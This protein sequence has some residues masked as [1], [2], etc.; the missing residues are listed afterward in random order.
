MSGQ[1]WPV[2]QLRVMWAGVE[3]ADPVGRTVTQRGPAVRRVMETGHA[4]AS[5]ARRTAGP[6]WVTVR[7]TGT[8]RPPSKKDVAH[9]GAPSAAPQHRGWCAIMRPVPDEPATDVTV[10]IVSF[11][12]RELL[13]RCL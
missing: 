6:R 9:R 1:F 12:T 2:Q 10:C 11:N 5:G 3:A 7:P 8:G 4:A 13:R